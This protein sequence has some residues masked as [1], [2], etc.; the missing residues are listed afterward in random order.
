VL[1]ARYNENAQV[2]K[3]AIG[4]A[5]RASMKKMKGHSLLVEKPEGKETPR[6]T[7]T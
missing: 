7:K 5:F 2:E 6:K 4:G 3:D 1:L